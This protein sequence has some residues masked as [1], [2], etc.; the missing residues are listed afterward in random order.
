M[1]LLCT[2][3]IILSEYTNDS[4]TFFTSKKTNVDT[5]LE[6]IFMF[7]FDFRLKVD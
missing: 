5:T 4:T 3:Q 1:L 2:N 7:K 6:A